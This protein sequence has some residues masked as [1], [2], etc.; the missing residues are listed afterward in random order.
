MLSGVLG[1]RLDNGV[2]SVVVR[3]EKLVELWLLTATKSLSPRSLVCE[4]I[5]R[6]NEGDF[7]AGELGL[8]VSGLGAKG[9]MI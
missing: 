7:V 3:V 6:G 1:T 5:L 8:L 4:P 9:G 2:S